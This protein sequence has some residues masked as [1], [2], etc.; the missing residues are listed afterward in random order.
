LEALAAEYDVTIAGGDTN[1]WRGPFV[2]NVTLIGEPL[3]SAPLL[4]SGAKPGDVLM[5][6]GACGGSIR[7][8]HLHFTPRLDEVRHLLEIIT[9]HAM[10]DIS[11]G[12]AADLHH[13]LDESHVGAIVD[14]A[15][16]PIHPDTGAMTDNV[17][18]LRH[19]LSDGEDFELLFTVGPDDVARLS[20][21]WKH[22]TPLTAIGEITAEKSVLLREGGTITSLPP[23]G[24]THALS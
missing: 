7:G 3:A 22:A 8:R 23:W 1:S 10:I 12:L 5:V 13:L 19:A 17:P 11:D 6:T 21:A 24:W 4:R 14:A 18:P 16:I 2:I 15:A 9:P 20:A